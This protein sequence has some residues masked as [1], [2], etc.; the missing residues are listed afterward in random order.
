MK[1]TQSHS[2][3]REDLSLTVRCSGPQEIPSFFLFVCTGGPLY[4][5]RVNTVKIAAGQDKAEKR[6]NRGRCTQNT[7]LRGCTPLLKQCVCKD[8]H[9]EHEEQN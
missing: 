7:F 5:A 6:R 2:S 3:Q 1:D 4:P 8:C 9:T